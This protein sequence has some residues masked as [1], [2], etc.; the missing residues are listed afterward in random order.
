MGHILKCIKVSSLNIN[1]RKYCRVSIFC[2]TKGT[3]HRRQATRIQKW[4]LYCDKFQ[5]EKWYRICLPLCSNVIYGLLNTGHLC[6]KCHPPSPPLS[7]D[8]CISRL[9]FS[10]LIGT[11]Q[12]HWNWRLIQTPNSLIQA[13]VCLDPSRLFFPSHRP[14]SL[15]FQSL[16]GD[17]LLATKILFSGLDLTLLF[18]YSRLIDDYSCKNH[19]SI[20]VRSAWPMLTFLH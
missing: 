1:H 20:W 12:L 7:S 19:P 14:F 10:F 18:G 13:L 9:W 8:N 15:N 5:H 2:F 3:T 11:V 16:P 17:L 6:A 4:P